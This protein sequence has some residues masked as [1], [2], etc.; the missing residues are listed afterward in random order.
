MIKKA[1]LPGRQSPGFWLG[2]HGSAA[3]F[4]LPS[5]THVRSC[6]FQM[7][8]YGVYM[9]EFKLT[10]RVPNA[11]GDIGRCYRLKAFQFDLRA[12]TFPGDKSF[13]AEQ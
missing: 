13:G 6:Y 1:L 12:Q 9:K 5:D 4:R 11:P 10:R 2:V 8:V 7:M 3:P